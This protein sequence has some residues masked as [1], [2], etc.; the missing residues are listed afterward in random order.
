MTPPE[1]VGRLNISGRPSQQ[2]SPADIARQIVRRASPA[3]AG[4]DSFM[5]TVN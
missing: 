3:A 4:N 1:P 2:D 5:Q